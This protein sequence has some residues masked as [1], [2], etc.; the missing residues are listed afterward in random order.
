MREI[1]ELQLRLPRRSGNRAEQL[2]TLPRFRAGY[3][4]VLLRE[5]AGEDLGGLGE[6]WTHYQ[7]GNENER[8]AMV[9]ALPKNGG[10]RKR[11]RRRP[12]RRPNASQV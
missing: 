6:W 12:N 3:D 10:P 4:F 2:A 8:L 5:Q 1:W 11:R 9:A 7:N